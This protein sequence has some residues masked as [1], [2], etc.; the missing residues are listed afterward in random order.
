M[1]LKENLFERYPFI[2]ND[3]LKKK[4]RDYRLGSYHFTISIF[5]GI[6]LLFFTFEF[7]KNG[8]DFRIFSLLHERPMAYVSDFS[9]FLNS[10]I[11]LTITP[12]FLSAL[13]IFIHPK[14]RYYILNL[15]EGK[16]INEFVANE[17]LS[18]IGENSDISLT[19][20]CLSNSEFPKEL[21][22]R[23]GEGVR[24]E[25]VNCLS[26]IVGDESI[27][28]DSVNVEKDMKGSGT[29]KVFS[30]CIYSTHVPIPDFYLNVLAKD[31]YL[32]LEDSE[33]FIETNN[34]HL[35]KKVMRDEIVDLVELSVFKFPEREVSKKHLVNLVFSPHKLIIDEF[36]EAG[37]LYTKGYE[38]VESG[39]VDGLWG[40]ALKIK[41]IVI[42]DS[43]LHV[44]FENPLI[45][46]EKEESTFP[47]EIISN[48]NMGPEE[49]W[50]DVTTIQKRM[51]IIK[52]IKGDVK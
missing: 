30:G 35:A 41:S 22:S 31:K 12:L 37:K 46:I 36:K 24:I 1:N 10:H 52:L 32:Y 6:V 2:V 4:M 45:S 42:K 15:K 29:F 39:N 38:E 7:A 20:S 21:F 19:Y 47:F 51:N 48:V 28:I 13:Y 5:L 11:Y 14:A 50:E 33:Y 25:T 43:I 27:I 26:G 40:S 16:L 17:L 44:S 3:N 23:Y 9:S 8:E 49:I 18:V 34:P